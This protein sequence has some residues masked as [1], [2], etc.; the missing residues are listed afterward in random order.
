MTCSPGN[1]PHADQP[2]FTLADYLTMVRNG[3]AEW[4]LS[5]AS[6]ISGFSR[7]HLLRCMTL[8]SVPQDVFDQ[9]IADMKATGRRLTTSG[10]ASE[11]RRR[12]GKARTSEE[13]CPHCGEVL[14]TRRR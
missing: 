6:R 5:E 9:I 12:T 3:E 14:R 13:R 10:L 4:S 8:A 7:A 2:N 11:I 1:N